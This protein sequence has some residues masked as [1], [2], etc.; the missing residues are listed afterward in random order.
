M[1]IKLLLVSIT[2]LLFLNVKATIINANPSNYASL[3][4]TLL[5]GDTLMLASGNYTDRLNIF[6]LVGTSSNP[7]VII[8]SGN[9]NIFL[10]NPCC[11]TVSIK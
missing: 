9:N 6:S 3:L 11:N 8:G 2:L 7:I 5:Q 10:H 4:T 1:K